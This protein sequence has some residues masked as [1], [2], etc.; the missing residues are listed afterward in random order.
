MTPT[1]QR[2]LTILSDCRKHKV[3]E[4]VA[5]LTDELGTPAHMRVHLAH[6]RKAVRAEGQDI[7]CIDGHYVLTGPV[8]VSM[9]DTADAWIAKFQRRLEA[10]RSF[11]RGT[12]VPKLGWY[13]KTECELSNN[14]EE[15]F[16]VRCRLLGE[17]PPGASPLAHCDSNRC[18]RPDHVYW[19]TALDRC[20]DAL[21]K[22]KRG[23]FDY[24][25]LLAEAE[26]IVEAILTRL[27]S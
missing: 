2:M 14:L 20:R 16:T 10:L 19:G 22:G 5:C 8:D 24:K 23:A 4:L 15:A 21:L 1:Q 18:V 9:P 6:L 25:R 27:E 11:D 3:D 17:R 12:F 26:E 13:P 7:A